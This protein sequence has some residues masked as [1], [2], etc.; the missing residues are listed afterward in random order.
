MC[1]SVGNS[2]YGPQA[3]VQLAGPLREN[4]PFMPLKRWFARKD[5]ASVTLTFREIETILGR[6][7]SPSVRKYTS[8]WYTR[9]DR[10]AMAEAWVTEGYKL[11]RLDLEREKVTFHREEDGVSHV[12]IPDWLTAGK[13]PDEARAEIEDFFQYIRKKHGI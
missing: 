8:R 5:C 10:N 4:W 6:K 3:R 12:K 13:I 9:P 11:F 2:G 7:L 1:G